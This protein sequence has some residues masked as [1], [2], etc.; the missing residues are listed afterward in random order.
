[1]SKRTTKSEQEAV[2]RVAPLSVL[3]PL[4]RSAFPRVRVAFDFSHPVLTKQAF[5][6]ECDVNQI[7]A[8]FM[9]T[10]E[11]PEDQAR[12]PRFEDVSG[13]GSYQDAMFLVA[14]ARSMF[15]ALPSHVRERFGNDPAQLLAFGEDPANAEEMVK[16][17]L[18]EPGEQT[19][20]QG[21]SGGTSSPGEP[22]AALAGKGE[23]ITPP[24]GASSPPGA[25]NSTVG[26]S[27][28]SSGSGVKG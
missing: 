22:P 24:P 10:G 27:P 26:A 1:M 7:I 25:A 3:P 15:A 12:V 18:A 11:L 17:G 5:K 14:E 13:L 23:G 28:P 16:L 21:A 8:R 4:R 19:S 6:D 2:E 20:P 9:K